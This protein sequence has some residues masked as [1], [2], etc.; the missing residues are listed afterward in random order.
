VGAGFTITV[1]TETVVAP[2]LSRAVIVSKYVPAATPVAATLRTARPELASAVSNV[3]PACALELCR[4]KAKSAVPP[5]ERVVPP[6]TVKVS[7]AVLPIV[8]VMV[9]LDSD[10]EGGALI[11]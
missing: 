6:V 1:K 11:V 4:V 9:E 5:D 2:R 7:A 8:V 3:I 10:A